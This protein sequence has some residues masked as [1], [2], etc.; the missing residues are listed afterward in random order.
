RRLGH[1]TGH[2]QH[3][4]RTNRSHRHMIRPR[5]TSL[6]RRSLGLLAMTGIAALVAAGCGSD[7]KDDSSSTASAKDDEQTTLV[8]YSGREQEI[9]E[10][11]Y[12]QFEEQT[13]VKLDVRYGDSAALVAQ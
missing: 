3:S 10:P 2:R 7:S 4:P 11:L 8:V 12:E 1:H 6:L 5:S 13:G 9:V